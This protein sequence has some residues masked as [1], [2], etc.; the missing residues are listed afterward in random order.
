M[1]PNLLVLPCVLVLCENLPWF[2]AGRLGE[3]QGSLLTVLSVTV[4]GA[5]VHQEGRSPVGEALH[6]SSVAFLFT[7]NFKGMWTVIKY[8]IIMTDLCQDYAHL[9]LWV[10]LQHGEGHGSPIQYFHLKTPMD[11]GAWRATVH[12]VTKSRTR[13]STSFSVHWGVGSRT[14]AYPNP[15]VFKSLMYKRVQYRQ[16]CVSLDVEPMVWD[17][18]GLLYLIKWAIRL[19]IYDLLSWYL[20]NILL[21]S[22]Q[23]AEIKAALPGL[24]SCG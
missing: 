23:W 6:N 19:I 16:P 17:T 8:V 11:R 2:T 12:G 18:E 4:C 21:K 15:Q 22:P 20:M 10:I 3:G 1:E 24:F 14:P 13:P 9:C 7:W 5:A